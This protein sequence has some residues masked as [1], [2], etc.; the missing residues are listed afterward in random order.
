MV[1]VVGGPFPCEGLLFPLFLLFFFSVLFLF[2]FGALVS[3]AL[4]QQQRLPSDAKNFSNIEYSASFPSFFFFFA[5]VFLL[6]LLHE[7]LV[8][9]SLMH[10]ISV[11]W[12]IKYTYVEIRLNELLIEFDRG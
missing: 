7:Y 1:S 4:F 11:W 9:R 6:F 2:F 5:L 10:G 12:W 8:K 3:R